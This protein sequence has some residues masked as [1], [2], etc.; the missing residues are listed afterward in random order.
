MLEVQ[1][2]ACPECDLLLELDGLESGQRARCPR[3]DRFLTSQDDGAT[4]RALSFA[5]AA[6][7]LLAM[8]N[9]FPFLELHASGLEKVMT[10]PRAGAELYRDGYAVLAG[11]VLLPIAVLPA[12][13]LVTMIALLVPLRR[14]SR[15]SWLVP[16]GRLL[17]ALNPWNMVEV[18]I[19]GVLVSLVKIGAMATVI[20]GI[21]FWAY[22]GFVLC[23][24]AAIG[25]LDRFQ[26]WRE[27]EACQA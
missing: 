2:N 25:S 1:R 19:I 17:F 14:R 27:I 22:I 23:F 8:A 26:L 10:I 16:T 20:I 21:S 11:M 15:S 18:F 9:S 7:V 5:L 3:C 12:V 4:N 24:I 13:M 6:A